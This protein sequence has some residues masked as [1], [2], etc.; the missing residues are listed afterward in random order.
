MQ[1]ARLVGADLLQR[2]RP[3]AERLWAE[4][5]QLRLGRL[6][7]EQPDS[8]PLLRSGLRQDEPRATFEDELERGRLRPLLARPEVPQPA[9]GHQVHEQ[10]ELPV[11]GREE[12]AL[13]PPPGALEAAPFERREGRIEGL[14]RGDVRGARPHDRERRDGRVELAPPCLHLR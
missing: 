6:R 2:V 14:Q 5:G 13:G 10:D 7:R 4:V 11:V 12:Q 3:E 1:P 9:G 8:R